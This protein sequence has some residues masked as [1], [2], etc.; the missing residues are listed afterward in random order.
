MSHLDQEVLRRILAGE[1][2]PQEVEAAEEHLVACE[3][4]RAV[5]GHLRSETPGLAGGPLRLVN[6]LIDRELQW[7]LDYMAVRHLKAGEIKKAARVCRRALT[8]ASLAAVSHDQMRTVWEQLL[9]AT[10]ATAA[11]EHQAISDEALSDLRRYL[12]VHWKHPAVTVP[13]VG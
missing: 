10:T 4:C 11:T 6:D 9:A 2:G 3:L 8:D 12:S 5:A 1:G 13:A 7:S